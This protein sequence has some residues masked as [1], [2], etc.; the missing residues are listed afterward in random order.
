MSV[1]DIIREWPELE[2][3]EVC[4]ALAFAATGMEEDFFVRHT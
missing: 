2:A 1:A 3:E 4:Q